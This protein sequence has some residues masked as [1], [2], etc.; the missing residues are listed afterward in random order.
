MNK[1]EFLDELRTRLSKLPRAD[2]EE[3]LN[4]YSEMIDDRIEEGIAEEDAVS[5]VGSVDEIA[6]QIKTDIA[7]AKKPDKKVRV[8][9]KLNAW[10]IVLLVLGSP[11]WFSLALAAFVVIIS[12]YI[13]LWAVVGSLWALPVSLIVCPFSIA[14]AG[15]MFIGSGNLFGGLA[16]IG[17]VFI[18]IGLA[19]FSFL[20]CRELTKGA[21]WL[22]KK[23]ALGLKNI[24]AKKEDV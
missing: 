12:L 1:Q 9:R 4:F 5:A 11:I 15:V 13:S 14:V 10:E 3:R 7:S 21:V 2:V 8:K 23:G 19:I 16:L 22:T 18:C 6:E 20:G 24:F 17:S